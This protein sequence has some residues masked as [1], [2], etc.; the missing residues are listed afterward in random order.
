MNAAERQRDRTST[1]DAQAHASASAHERQSTG[2]ITARASVP[3][4]FAGAREPTT[5]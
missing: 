2:A 1:R 3:V 5:H 4:T